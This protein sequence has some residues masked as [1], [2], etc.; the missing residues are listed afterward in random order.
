MRGCFS[1]SQKPTSGF[2]DGCFAGSRA[3]PE[4][5]RAGGDCNRGAAVHAG[6]TSGA[7]VALALALELELALVLVLEL[8]LELELALVLA[9]VLVLVLVLALVLAL[10]LAAGRGAI[11]T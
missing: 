4:P 9:L 11:S 5:L 8:V 1:E 2:F 7:A 6:R 10:A 3:G